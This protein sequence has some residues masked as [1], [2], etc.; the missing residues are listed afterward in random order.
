MGTPFKN[1]GYAPVSYASFLV[2]ILIQSNSCHL[3]LSIAE[4][5]KSIASLVAQKTQKNFSR[6]SKKIWSFLEIFLSYLIIFVHFQ[7]HLIS[8]TFLIGT[9]WQIF[10]NNCQKV[11]QFLT[12]N[13]P[14]PPRSQ[15]S[16]RKKRIINNSHYKKATSIKFTRSNVKNVTK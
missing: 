15:M 2:K 13:H 10:L 3:F 16:S 11:S 6:W 5:I 8:F 14:R 7:S 4:N 12:N 9:F 1:P